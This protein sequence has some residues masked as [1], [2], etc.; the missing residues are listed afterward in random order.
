MTLEHVKHNFDQKQKLQ[1]TTSNPNK[2]GLQYKLVLAYS[3]E[4]TV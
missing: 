2:T 3:V 1:N 4:Y